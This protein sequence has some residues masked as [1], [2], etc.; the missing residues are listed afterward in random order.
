VIDTSA[1]FADSGS[2]S[3]ADVQAFPE[4]F[5][6]SLVAEYT[7]GVWYTL[8]GNGAC[9]NATTLGSL[10]DTILSVYTGEKDCQDLFCLT[11]N[12]D[13]D[14]SGYG[15][16]V[17]SNVFFRTEVGQTYY[18]LLAGLGRFSSGPYRFSL[19]V[20]ICCAVAGPC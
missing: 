7:Q 10:F 15:F 19:E 20:R 18:I 12:D 14:N 17:N 16:G 2:T 13:G 4:V 11:E 8:E 9:Y 5:T 3:F 6:C 1:P